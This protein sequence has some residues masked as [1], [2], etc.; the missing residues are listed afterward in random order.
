M[1]GEAYRTTAA[2]WSA[3]TSVALGADGMAFTGSLLNKTAGVSPGPGNVTTLNDTGL[4]VYDRAAPALTL[5]LREGGALLGSTVKTFNALVARPGSGGQGRGAESDG[6]EDYTVFRAMLADGR[7]TVGYVDMLG[8]V[9]P[10]YTSGDGAVGY[11]SGALWLGFGLPTQN[12]AASAM[13][14]LG[15]V[16]SGTGTATSANNVA[17]FA[18][19]DATY[20]PA[21]LVSKGD[22]AAGVSGGIFSALKDPVSAG[23]RSVA[24]LG[25]MKANGT[26][27]T[28]ADDAGIWHRSDSSALALVA[29]ENAQ[30]PEAPAGAKWKAFTSL[31]LPEG[32]GPLFV[33]SM[34]SKI[35]TTSP[36]PGGITTANDIGLWATDSNGALRLLLQ[37]GDVI[38]T[39][40][41]KSFTVLSTVAGSPAQTR[42]FNAGGSVVLKVTDM[43]GAQH[44]VQIAVP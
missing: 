2:V 13:A 44:L 18:E 12:A 22:A 23:N 32:R 4:W 9:T 17:I 41:V 5:A 39:S 35:G 19:E 20:A 24:F 7:S 37:E 14:F 21:R 28:S 34:H 10:L 43:T 36:G 33:A 26:T 8:A 11:D 40:T 42:G 15:T 6:D 31:A 38:G 1:R 30:P 25:T 27:I 29:R 3:F 16:K